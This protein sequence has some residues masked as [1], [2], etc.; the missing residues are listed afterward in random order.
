MKIVAC[1]S[2]S[3]SNETH[4]FISVIFQVTLRSTKITVEANV[5][6]LSLVA[7]ERPSEP[8]VGMRSLLEGLETRMAP[9]L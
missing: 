2:Q 7:A 5:L 6:A 1:E 9:W 8:P 3:F 4:F